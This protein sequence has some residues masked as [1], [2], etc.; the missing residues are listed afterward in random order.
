MTRAYALLKLL[1]HGELTRRE[2]REITFWP[3]RKV[4]GTLQ[5]LSDQGKIHQVRPRTWGLKEH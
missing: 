3:D 2:I 5:Y 1:E 4:I